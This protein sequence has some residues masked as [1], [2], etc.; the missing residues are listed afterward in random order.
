MCDQLHQLDI[1]S[2]NNHVP[3]N[4]ARTIPT[5]CT[6]PLPSPTTNGHLQLAGTTP[7]TTAITQADSKLEVSLGACQC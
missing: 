4:S 1:S 3:T 6:Q 2:N 7:T 5:G